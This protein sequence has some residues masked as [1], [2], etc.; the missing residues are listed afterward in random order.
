MS[1]RVRLVDSPAAAAAIQT[2]EILVV[3]E[4]TVEYVEAIRKAKAVIAEIGGMESH[5]AVIAQSTGIPTIVGVANAIASLLQGEI[6][7]LDLQRGEV[8]RGA[9]S[10]N[11]DPNGAIV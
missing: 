10:H 7:T 11:S 5:A 1:G 4:T 3:R 2:G 9:R 8:H 6:V